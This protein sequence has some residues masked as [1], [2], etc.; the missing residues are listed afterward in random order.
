VRYSAC[1]ENGRKDGRGV[2]TRVVK[3]RSLPDGDG[4][5]VCRNNSAAAY[6]KVVSGRQKVGEEGG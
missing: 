1:G 2:Q 5:L 6:E 4:G 3:P